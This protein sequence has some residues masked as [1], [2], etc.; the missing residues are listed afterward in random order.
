MVNKLKAS[1]D[2]DKIIDLQYKI[3]NLSII[4]TNADSLTNKLDELKIF[5][6][7]QKI[8]PNII[9]VVEVNPKNMTDR[10]SE[11]D[12]IMSGYNMYSVNIG[13]SG[14][15]GIIIFVEKYIKSSIRVVTVY[16]F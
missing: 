16:K 9:V 8:K 12:F 10:F 11:K 4:Y 3:N 2:S 7:S 5:L 13:I 1:D 6:N 14:K 15:R